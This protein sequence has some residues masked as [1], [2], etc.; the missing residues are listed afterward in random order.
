MKRCSS[1]PPTTDRN[2]KRQH[3]APAASPVVRRGGSVGPQL[4][5]SRLAEETVEGGVSPSG[6]VS[7]DEPEEDEE[8]GSG[9]DDEGEVAFQALTYP[10]PI[11]VRWRPLPRPASTA[12]TSNNSRNTIAGGSG[13]ISGGNDNTTTAAAN[14]AAQAHSS[15]PA[16][17]PMAQPLL[18]PDREVDPNPAAPTGSSSRVSAAAL[19]LAIVTQSVGFHHG[20]AGRVV[21]VR[22]ERVNDI[23]LL[24]GAPLLVGEDG[25]EEGGEQGQKVEDGQRKEG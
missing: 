17:L 23:H 5:T 25:R 9:E 10:D 19:R 15:P 2:A 20:E 18:V 6:V 3:L 14:P 4:D 8:S 21:V 11:E 22:S 1:A 24:E 7:D 16:A 13:N 12:S